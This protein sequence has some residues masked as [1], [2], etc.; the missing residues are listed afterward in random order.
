[1]KQ[2]FGLLILLSLLTACVT[3]ND[4]YGD[5]LVSEPYA[6]TDETDYTCYLDHSDLSARI[7]YIGIGSTYFI[8]ECQIEN[9]ST[10]TLSI[11]SAEF[12]MDVYDGRV[13][14]ALHPEELSIQLEDEK[15][16]LKKEKKKRTLWNSIITGLGIL[17]TATTGAPVA[18]NILFSAEPIAYI[19]EERSFYQRNIASVKDEISYVN[20]MSMSD[21]RIPPGESLTRDLH[22]EVQLVTSDVD[23]IYT[24]YRRESRCMFNSD[25][26]DTRR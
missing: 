22:F 2:V 18:E 26:F 10:D 5:P 21:Y 17:A 20:E 9:I 15:R 19:F 12:A 13:V 6:S 23:I 8:F 4:W 24:R 1:M 25:L 7:T 14:P 11:S 3:T 16:Q